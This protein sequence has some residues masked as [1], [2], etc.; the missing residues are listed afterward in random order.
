MA[1]WSGLRQS[2]TAVSSSGVNRRSA[3]CAFTKSANRCGA[4][5]GSPTPIWA[6][7]CAGSSTEQAS[8]AST[9]SPTTSVTGLQIRRRL[10]HPTAPRSV[11]IRAGAR[12]SRVMELHRARSCFVWRQHGKSGAT[13]PEPSLPS[14]GVEC[15][16]GGKRSAAQLITPSDGSPTFCGWLPI[17]PRAN[18]DGRAAGAS[19][20]RSRSKTSAGNT[21]HAALRAAAR[22]ARDGPTSAPTHPCRGP[23]RYSGNPS[24]TTH[25]SR[26]LVWILTRGGTSFGLSRLAVVMPISSGKSVCSPVSWVPQ[27]EQNDRTVF[28]VELNRTGRPLMMRNSIDLT[29]N[30]LRNGAPVVRR[31]IEQWQFVSRN[32]APS[33]S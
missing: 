15:W 3:R 17:S 26:L 32:G 21:R 8:I 7:A 19:R 28:A 29:L 9:R 20:H 2:S 24:G 1:A 27:R 10:L 22:V 25:S 12:S 13:T 4:P 6:G 23:S 5:S 11:E 31:Q 14:R 16:R 18:F 30:M 33:T